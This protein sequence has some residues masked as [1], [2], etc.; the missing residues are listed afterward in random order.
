MKLRYSSSGVPRF[1][2]LTLSKLRLNL[3]LV[4]FNTFLL[5]VASSMLFW[6]QHAPVDNGKRTTLYSVCPWFCFCP[7][8]SCRALFSTS[9]YLQVTFAIYKLRI[10]LLLIWADS[11]CWQQD[12]HDWK[13][14]GAERLISEKPS[15]A[16][17]IFARTNVSTVVFSGCV[18]GP[19]LHP[20]FVRWMKGLVSTSN[21]V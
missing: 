11:G 9:S 5:S 7:K 3:D 2:P 14:I 10:M 1:Q 20:V 19:I 17:A 15:K 16:R 18:C 8:N 13:E 6:M 21:G 4:T 12:A